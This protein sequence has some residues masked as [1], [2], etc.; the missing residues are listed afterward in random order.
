MSLLA[1]KV[2]FTCYGTSSKQVEERA[3]E[4]VRQYFGNVPHTHSIQVS[5][6][7]RDLSHETVIWT[8]VVT[9]EKNR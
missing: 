5:A 1:H 7:S 9:G 2:T 3:E 6:T 8:A 4:V